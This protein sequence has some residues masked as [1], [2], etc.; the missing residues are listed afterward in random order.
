MCM[1]QFIRIVPVLFLIIF[2]SA[3]N[4][5]DEKES[6]SE[7]AYSQSSDVVGLSPIDTNDSVSTTITNQIYDTLF[8]KDPETSD[9]VPHLI[10][11]YE[12]INETT[13]EFT[14]IEG[15]KF[16]DDTDLNAEAVKYTF[17][18]LR[19][20]ERAA[21]RASLLDS[22][23]S[24]E[25]TDEYTFVIKTSY[26]YGPLLSSLTHVS[27]A[28]VS[29]TADQKQ[30]LMS[31]P[32][33]S[34][35]FIFESRTTGDKIVLKKNENYFLGEPSI[36]KVTM[37]VVPEPSS[38]VNMLE[39]GQIDFLH[40]I[41]S[42]HIERVNDLDNVN[43]ESDPGTIVNFVAFN[44]EKEPFNE[45]EFRKAVSHSINRDEYVEQLNG[46]GVRNNS[47]IGPEVLGY[48]EEASEWGFNFDLETA[49]KL[50]EENNYDDTEITLM[51]PNQGQFP[52]MGEIVQANLME[53]G[54]DVE[55][56]M[57]EWAAFLEAAV[58]GDYE[59]SLFSWANVTADG[60]ELFYPN[61]HSDNIGSRNRSRYSN[62][63]FDQLV[64]A[65]R[66]SVDL[67]ER[68]ELLHQ[69]N[70]IITNEAIWIPMHHGNMV[71]A[72]NNRVENLKV[73]AA[74]YFSLY[75][76]TVDQEE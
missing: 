5:N 20:P 54:F 45:L 69:A 59:M 55:I 29:P 47:A 61:L 21:P 62:E 65:S 25:V 16:H 41:S 60:S 31:E 24:I 40:N 64:D 53:A 72:I 23:E 70:E 18:Q 26:P 49:Q 3:C 17:D 58:A 56:Q 75:G 11:D 39:T 13:W 28:I 6:G 52:N 32:V 66:E 12:I 19:D 14:L 34:G 22:V 73:N 36:D 10:D 38:A 1:K 63:E 76:V 15:I 67:D 9:I 44:M 2:I 48:V 43:V 51:V 50:I 7:I 74:G 42:E 46:V 68:I 27:S 57:V 8:V 71:S 30:D 33:G 4:S 37:H 35:P